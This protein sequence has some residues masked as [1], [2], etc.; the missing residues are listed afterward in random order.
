MMD[1]IVVAKLGNIATGVSIAQSPRHSLSPRFV[2]MQV[3]EQN[4]SVALTK[5]FGSNLKPVVSNEVDNSLV[6]HT[7]AH[8]RS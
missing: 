5:I 8:A 4:F 1:Q 3:S 6:R 2:T 7:A